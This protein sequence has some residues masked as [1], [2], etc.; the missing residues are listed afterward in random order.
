MTP[1]GVLSWLTNRSAAIDALTPLGPDLQPFSF[2]YSGW[3]ES[4][5]LAERDFR[6]RGGGFVEREEALSVPAVLRGRNMICS[7]ATLPLE[8]V[9]ANNVV[10]DHPL[11]RQVDVNVPNVVTMGQTVEDLLFEAVAWWRITGFG[12]DGYPVSAIRVDPGRVQLNPPPGYS[13][14]QL[15]SGLTPRGVVWM[16]GV[17]V[18]K[19]E[20]IR[21][22]SPN[23]ALLRSAQRAIS[24]AIALD[25]AAEMY[26]S[27][28][29]PMD[30]FTPNDAAADP[31]DDTRIEG[32]LNSWRDARRRRSTAYVPA[33]LTYN[34]VQQPTPADLQLVQLQQRASL[35]IA[36]A[37]GI[38]P[39][40]LGISTTSR[41]YQ[42]AT[43]RRKDR[44]NDVLAP[45]MRAITD[46]LS[47]PD[48]TKRG[49]SVRHNLD[50]YLKADPK[51]RAEVQQ[52]YVTMGVMTPEYVGKSEGLAPD[53][54]PDA[55]PAPPV[56]ATVGEPESA[57]QI[58]AA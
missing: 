11:L 12:W 23:P 43:D 52:T 8:A 56:Q 13:E 53:S 15:P 55:P 45:Y 18:P 41:T 7:I 26:A 4:Q 49:V 6:R 54:I 14:S 34:E 39:E 51:T 29:R 9:N 19:S 44:I 3:R 24:R 22:D 10:Q 20:V 35:D 25:E 30:Y 36:N 27:E 5:L 48:V 17:A 31:A 33:A 1:M 38:D 16:D 28:P 57:R 32:I 42:N 58:E 37:L 21:F 50:D 47:M 46:R 2:G 40:D